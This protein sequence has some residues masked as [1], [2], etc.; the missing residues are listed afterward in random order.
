MTSLDLDK[1]CVEDMYHPLVLLD[2]VTD[3]TERHCRE[4][5]LLTQADVSDYID[6]P[7]HQ[8]YSC[9]LISICQANSWHPLEITKPI[10]LSLL[11]G[12]G[13]SQNVYDLISCFYLRDSD[14]EDAYCV[15]FT[16][17]SSSS[18][19]EIQYSIRYPEYKEHA[20]EWALRQT[21]VCHRINTRTKQSI[22]LLI[23]PTPDS[24]GHNILSRHLTRSDVFSGI[25][26]C[27]MSAHHALLN[28]Y[29]PAW[30]G[31][32]AFHEEKFLPINNGTF[33]S[34]IETKRL[35][36]DYGQLSS[37]LGILARVTTSTTLLTGATELMVEMKNFLATRKD[38]IESIT[39][40]ERLINATD[41]LRRRCAADFR[42]AN[43]LEERIKSS[44]TL[45]AQTLAFRDQEIA[46]EQ[47]ATMLELNKSAVFQN[48]NMLE[49]NKSAVFITM[50][51]LVYAPASFVATFFGMNFFAMDQ[52]NSRI[53]CT[54]MVWIY[55]LSTGLLTGITVMLYF[56]L[57][58]NDKV[59]SWKGR[60]ELRAKGKW[61]ARK[62]T[63]NR[64]DS[65]SQRV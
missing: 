21:A 17:S 48:A 10:L 46:K 11:N 37:L 61:L 45:L 35:P 49:L 6:A 59:L 63:L 16:V 52:E 22:I 13:F 62:M 2:V 26:A 47:N 30:R 50:L 56:W 58:Q 4:R 54:S 27:W 43:F 7:N 32:N 25:K 31:F 33:V 5:K 12:H 9:R 40:S 24:R 53:V 29:L 38:V 18:W 36:I 55:I 14:S 51:S 60:L 57:I 41:N 20:G 15:P 1:S 64:S 3:G 42:V 65:A 8:D 28:G 34:Y 23:S 44:S 19:T 39:V